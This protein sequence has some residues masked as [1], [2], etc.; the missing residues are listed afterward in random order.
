MKKCRLFVIGAVVLAGLAAGLSAGRAVS[1]AGQPASVAG[2]TVPVAEETVSVAGQALPVAGQPASVAAGR[3]L[4]ASARQPDWK[5]GIQTYTFHAF[6]LMETL[7]KTER[8]GLKYAEAFFFQELGAPFP[9]ETY[10]HY[11]LG[12]EDC[13]LLRGEFR[14]RGIRPIAFGVASYGTLEEWEKFFAF[15]RKIGAEIVTVEPELDQLDAIEALAEKY[16]MEV[17]IH[18]H[19]DPSLYASARVVAGALKGRSARMGVCAD[20][21]HWKRV[22]E[23]PLENLKMLAGRIKVAHLKDLNGDLE[24]ATWGTGILP[25][26]AFVH[27]LKRQ[28][29]GGLISIEYENFAADQLRDIAESLR[30]LEACAE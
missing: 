7:D 21:G 11:D 24:D 15:A 19:P 23:D 9:K 17:A 2:R 13:A 18:N 1:V 3:P 16:R 30:Y 8:L 26:E 29:F 27:E 25:V 22:G 10:L 12:E 20:I 5:V 6:T 4:P 14:K 28:G